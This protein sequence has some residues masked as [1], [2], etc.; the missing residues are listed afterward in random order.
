MFEGWA[1]E[2]NQIVMW[3]SC[4]DDFGF[5]YTTKPSLFV[6]EKHHHMKY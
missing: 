3:E 1:V 2:G 6:S 5:L 4:T